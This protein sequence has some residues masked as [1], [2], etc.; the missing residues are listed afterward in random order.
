MLR[1]RQKIKWL[2]EEASHPIN[3][4]WRSIHSDPFF[5]PRFFSLSDELYHIKAPHETAKNIPPKLRISSFSS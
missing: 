5:Q 1:A 4:A 3:F 2:D